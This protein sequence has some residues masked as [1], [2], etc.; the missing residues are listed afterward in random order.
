MY[1]TYATVAVDTDC[2]YTCAL[3]INYLL[4]VEGYSSKGSWFYSPGCYSANKDAPIPPGLGDFSLA[5]AQDCLVQE[6]AVY[7]DANYMEV[8]DFIASRL[9]D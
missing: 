8:F 7:I 9:M 3:F 4:S 6:D 2:P 1:P 5:Q